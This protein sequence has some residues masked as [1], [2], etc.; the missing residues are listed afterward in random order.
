MAV[1]NQTPRVTRVMQSVGTP[2][3]VDFPVLDD[4]W[5]RVLYGADQ[6]LVAT[7]G[8]DYTVLLAGDFSSFEITPTQAFFDKIG[9]T[10][11]ATLDITVER[12]TPVESDFTQEDAAFR[13]KL[14][15]ITDK[16]FMIAQENSMN[17]ADMRNALDELE[18]IVVLGQT[19][20]AAPIY[21]GILSNFGF[22]MPV[23]PRFGG[24]GDGATPDET[25]INNALQSGLPLLIHRPYRIGANTTFTAG[26]FFFVGPGRFIPSNGVQ[27]AFG[28]ACV[29][30]RAS[31]AQPFDVSLGGTLRSTS[32][33]T[34]GPS[35]K[36]S[37]YI[38]QNQNTVDMA[39]WKQA[40]RDLFN[41]AYYSLDLEGRKIIIDEPAVM[42]VVTGLTSKAV[43]K[44]ITNGELSISANFLT[45]YPVTSAVLSVT[46]TAN[47]AVA[48]MA[49]TAG[50][51]KGMY[52]IGAK[53][54]RATFILSVDSPTQITMTKKAM[55]SGVANVTRYDNNYIFDFR[56][57]TRLTRFTFEN[58]H[59]NCQSN[60]S[61]YMSSM[62]E[63]IVEFK[64]C[65]FV[66]P[67]TFAIC[68]Y[69]A[70]GG[71][72]V[73]GCDF[74]A[75]D[76]DTPPASRTRIACVMNGDCRINN[77]RTAYF[78]HAFVIDGGATQFLCNH[79]FAGTTDATDHLPNVIYQRSGNHV[80][81][82]N[83]I[84]NGWIEFTNEEFA[85]VAAAEV[86]GGIISGNRFV[87]RALAATE[88]FIVIAPYRANSVLAHMTIVGNGFKPLTS[89]G[90]V[91]LTAATK[92][93]TTNGTI[94]ATTVVDVF[95]SNNTFEQVGKQEEPAMVKVN[96]NSGNQAVVSFANK[97]PFNL[98]P[99]EA[100]GIVYKGANTIGSPRVTAVAGNNVTV[101]WVTAAAVSTDMIVTATCRTNAV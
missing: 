50:L 81:T 80:I 73:D 28:Q 8:T 21:Q 88:A 84:D 78:R 89:G 43:W 3:E 39:G 51:R 100:L 38:P 87:T 53:L 31:G 5:I 34:R 59:I 46:H 95:M 23:E 92:I 19:A 67:E 7:P 42:D 45:N 76:S 10:P 75:S 16:L 15:D 26:T 62:D 33:D 74:I 97:F 64:N 58:L 86:G 63:D 27:V 44:R 69:N 72:V 35:L 68:Q 41:L 30:N 85:G 71:M 22:A 6:D 36:I 2:V 1:N 12:A 13:R 17:S 48:T 66:N 4:A 32:P 14:R 77:N 61:A 37:D 101:D 20:D 29:I 83:Y 91:P 94:D 90:S 93:D 60:G 49:S 47:S 54:P 79:P 96:F 70:G 18:A 56:N 11:G 40:L 9:I 82:G 24:A 98:A 65:R 57:F 99:R 55:S 25:A 52:L